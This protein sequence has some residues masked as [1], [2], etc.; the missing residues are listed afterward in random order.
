MARG[1]QRDLARAKREKEKS[2]MKS[3][4]NKSGTQMQQENET[5]A[6]IMRRKQAAS[7]ARKAAAGL[8]GKK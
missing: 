5:A 1:N 6:E 8:A 3:G 7:D 2:K 4:T